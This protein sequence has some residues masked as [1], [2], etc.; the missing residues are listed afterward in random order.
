MATSGGLLA[1][2]TQDDLRQRRRMLRRQIAA[3]SLSSVPVLLTFLREN[4]AEYPEPSSRRKLLLLLPG[5]LFGARWVVFFF[6]CLTLAGYLANYVYR[7]LAWEAYF[8]FRPDLE[9]Y[10]AHRHDW[11]PNWPP[12]PGYDP[13]LVLYTIFAILALGG[14]LFSMVLWPRLYLLLADWRQRRGRVVW[15]GLFALPFAGLALLCVRFRSE[16]FGEAPPAEVTL[17]LAMLFFTPSVLIASMASGA[18]AAMIVGSPAPQ[19]DLVR[20]VLS[21]RMAQ[22]AL[23]NAAR[24]H[25]KRVSCFVCRTC[26]TRLTLTTERIFRVSYYSCRYCH[27]ICDGDQVWMGIRQVVAVLDTEMDEEPAEAAGIL[28]INWLKRLSLFDFDRAD[29]IAATD[30]DVERFCI[31]VANDT[32]EWRSRRYRN[33]TVTIK[34]SCVLSENTLMVLKS[35]FAKV[36]QQM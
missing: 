5:L 27:R 15:T 25:A 24:K 34:P 18:T 35:R 4:G 19:R 28:R 31:Q 10:R 8:R 11:P 2:L 1:E 30:Y 21:L 9:P 22:M 3:G 14:L 33:M 36:E 13:N 16:M 7:H 17:A 29:I 20:R 6:V 32:D 12:N 26:I 23:N